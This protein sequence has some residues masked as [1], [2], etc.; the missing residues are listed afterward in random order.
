MSATVISGDATPSSPRLRNCISNRRPWRA[1]YTTRDLRVCVGTV[2]KPTSYGLMGRYS[3]GI[4]K[5]DFR[6][7]TF[8]SSNPGTPMPFLACTPI[9]NRLTPH[10]VLTV[11]VNTR[12]GAERTQDTVV[13]MARSPD[14]TC[15]RECYHD[16]HGSNHAMCQKKFAFAHWDALTSGIHLVV[17]IVNAPGAQQA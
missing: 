8:P 6:F 11:S 5:V 13:T 17:D 3:S 1:P 9:R 14:T 12:T 4:G 10:V 2:L 15:G 16:K 7:N